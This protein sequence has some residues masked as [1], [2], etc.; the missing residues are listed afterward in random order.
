MTLI[1]LRADY[2]FVWNCSKPQQLRKKQNNDL[3]DGSEKHCVCQLAFRLFSG[4]L[5]SVDVSGMH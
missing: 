2:T 1:L 3:A 5:C 4:K